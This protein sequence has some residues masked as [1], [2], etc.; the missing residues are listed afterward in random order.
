[1]SAT[2]RDSD[3][4]PNPDML[5]SLLSMG[6][7]ENVAKEALFCTGNKID[8]AVNFIFSNDDGGMPNI[9]SQPSEISQ[10]NVKVTSVEGDDEEWED[11]D[12]P[13]QK[14]T[15]VVNI[16][17][18]MGTG[19]IAAQVGHACLGLYR[20]MLG[21]NLEAELSQWEEVGEKK[22][23]LKGNSAD[24]LLELYEKAKAAKVPAYIVRDAGHTQ[25]PSGSITVLSLFGPEEDVNKISGELS[26]L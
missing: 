7:A 11:E 17:L 18:K 6:I 8:D 10:A 25:I 2:D 5:N 14:M 19:K 9:P 22:I 23:V 16:S 21:A 4:Q 3:F 1:M 15:F 20:Q 26:L 12:V 24:H 13:Y